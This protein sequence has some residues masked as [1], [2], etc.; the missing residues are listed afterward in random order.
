MVLST[1]F[2]IHSMMVM[3]F[4]TFLLFLEKQELNVFFSFNPVHFVVKGKVISDR[5]PKIT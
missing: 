5:L 2:P 3:M 1:Y 4:H